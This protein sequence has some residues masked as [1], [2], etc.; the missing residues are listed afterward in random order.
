[1]SLTMQSAAEVRGLHFVSKVYNEQA[2]MTITSVLNQLK[3][4]PNQLVAPYLLKC[5]MQ[6]QAAFELRMVHI[7][8]RV[9]ARRAVPI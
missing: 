7:V 4:T 5:A 6:S 1:M 2:T 3:P 8:M 9:F